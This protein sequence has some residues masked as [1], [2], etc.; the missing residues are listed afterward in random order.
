MCESRGQF[1][2]SD[3]P[4]VAPWA[5]SVMSEWTGFSRIAAAVLLPRRLLGLPQT[6]NPNR[7]LC[8]QGIKDQRNLT[9]GTVRPVWRAGT[10]QWLA[11]GTGSGDRPRSFWQI[12]RDK[13]GLS[14]VFLSRVFQSV[15]TRRACKLQ[16]LLECRCYGT[17]LS[18]TARS[19]L[20]WSR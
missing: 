12:V 16:A 10:N 19:C 6:M 9:A 17:T 1:G 18:R 14:R 5:Q 3:K 20:R 13:R 2:S 4:R 7:L 15:K 8:Q 11:E